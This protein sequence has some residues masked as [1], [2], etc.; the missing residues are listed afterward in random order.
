[1]LVGLTDSR[2]G[3]KLYLQPQAYRVGF[4]LW[5]LIKL[6]CFVLSIYHSKILAIGFVIFINYDFQN[7]SNKYC[8]WHSRHYCMIKLNSSL[9]QRVLRGGGDDSSPLPLCAPVSFTNNSLDISN[10]KEN[11]L[12]T[13]TLMRSDHWLFF[14]TDNF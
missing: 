10:N 9:L 14:A 11:R 6:I 3:W 12:S 7:A 2:E 5:I 1:M 4:L 13:K 8:G